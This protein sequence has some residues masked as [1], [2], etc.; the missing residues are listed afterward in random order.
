MLEGFLE[1]VGIRDWNIVFLIHFLQKALIRNEP[2]TRF[3]YEG[4]TTTFLIG[5]LILVEKIHK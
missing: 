4:E 3:Y 1:F 2:N 5:A